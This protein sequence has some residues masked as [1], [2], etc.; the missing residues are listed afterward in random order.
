MITAGHGGYI[1][2]VLSQ[3]A[4]DCEKTGFRLNIRQKLAKFFDCLLTEMAPRQR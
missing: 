4:C 2:G 1:Q 3:A